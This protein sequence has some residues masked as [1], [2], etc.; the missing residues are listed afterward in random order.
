[1]V[2]RRAHK[3]EATPTEDR[4][5]ESYPRYNASLVQSLPLGIS[6]GKVVES[7]LMLQTETKEA[8]NGDDVPHGLPPCEGGEYWTHFFRV[9]C[10]FDS[11]TLTNAHDCG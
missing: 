2:A 8:A 6:A 3:S 5:F 4:R 7:R 1:M 10:L 9:V 11:G